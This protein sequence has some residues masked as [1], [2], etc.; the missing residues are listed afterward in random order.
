MRHLTA[1]VS[2]VEMTDS[3]G[4]EMEAVIYP[5]VGRR[6][7][8]VVACALGEASRRLPTKVSIGSY[9][10]ILCILLYTSISRVEYLSLKFVVVDRRMK[11]TNPHRKFAY[12]VRIACPD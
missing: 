6:V 5:R 4:L 11:V 12:V 8:H 2:D 3:D 7:S 10:L 1:R 9:F